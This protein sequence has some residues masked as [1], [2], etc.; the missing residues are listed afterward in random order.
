[1]VNSV[2]FINSVIVDVLKNIYLFSE[3]NKGLVIKGG[4]LN[5]MKKLRD[6]RP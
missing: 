5:K 2:D 3:K 4:Y 1:M 6:I